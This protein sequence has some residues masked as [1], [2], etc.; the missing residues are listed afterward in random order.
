MS[1]M[2]D[3]LD[4][5]VYYNVHVQGKIWV[6]DNEWESNKEKRAHKPTM[7]TRQGHIYMSPDEKLN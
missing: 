1:K 6:S 4:G 7:V 5:K 2:I 3:K